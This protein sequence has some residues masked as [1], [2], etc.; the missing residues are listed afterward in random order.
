MDQALAAIH[1]TA[2]RHD[3]L[4]IVCGACVGSVGLF[5]RPPRARAASIKAQLYAQYPDAEID[6][7]PEDSLAAPEGFCCVTASVWLE[8]HLFPI[9]RYAQA[10]D[11]L[12]R[13]LAD[14]VAGILAALT[15]VGDESIRPVIELS[16]QPASR[17]A[18]KRAKR[19]LKRLSRPTFI[20]H[21]AL[22]G[23][24]ARM[25]LSPRSTCRAMAWIL[26]R[27]AQHGPTLQ[28]HDP[29]TVTGSKG[30]DRE[31]DR[32]AAADKLGRHCFACRLRISVAA[33]PNRATQARAKISE[34]FGALGT[35]SQPRLASFRLSKRRRLPPFLLS[36]EEVA[37]LF[38]LPIAAVQHPALAE[39]NVRL[40][41]APVE[42]PN[43]GAGSDT[44]LLG[45]TKFR[46]ER[47]DVY[48]G[49]DALARHA[50]LT[51][52]TGQGKT[53][54][55]VQLILSQIQNNQSLVFI[56]PHGDAYDLV[57]AHIPRHRTNDVVLVDPADQSHAVTLNLLDCPDPR[58]RPQV[59]SAVVAAFQKVFAESW[60]PRLHYV[61]TNSV[62]ALLETPDC[63]LVSLVRLLS[64]GAFR[65]DV[66]HRLRDPGVRAFWLNEF[67]P[68]SPRQ[69]A[70]W[71]ASVQN[72]VGIFV[73]SPVLRNAFG[74]RTSTLN[75][76][77]AL[78]TGRVVLVNLST[79]RLG[80]DV[81]ALYGS[82]FVTAVQLAVFSR[83]DVAP[84]ARR[85]FTL[86]LDEFHFLAT[87]S[88]TT[89]LSEARKFGG[90]L[91][92]ATQFLEQLDPGT[93]AALSGNVGNWVVFQCGPR[94]AEMLASILGQPVAP[95][96]LLRLPQYH[97]IVRLLVDGYPTRPF[98]MTTL[99]LVANHSAAQNAD[100][101]RRT[102]RHRYAIQVS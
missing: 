84:V 38:H 88:L 17:H 37:S 66:V 90:R 4:T 75:L 95:E 78:D 87:T 31:D 43:R 42:L 54:V 62:L 40:F 89:F 69:K 45:R 80:A 74:H 70:D 92:C 83:A 47:R 96:D 9:R 101:L 68:L 6:E 64:D 97:A 102:S 77:Q 29:T 34:V 30:H 82:L 8:P 25:A 26:G 28:N 35:F 61:L 60:G 5:L 52:K 36:T 24:Y 32:Q 2:G 11:E 15:V 79:G 7:L 94:D 10:T 55:L 72:K 33:P 98:T 57:A 65:R 100:T 20:K 71:I 51:G 3:H 1:Q 48:L 99:P 81:A 49:S 39:P 53:T 86:F 56:D 73:T 67:E 23:W 18:M 59:A 19:V 93:L 21:T 14:P 85:P 41:P 58:L 22:A 46:G 44:V 12:N 27:F 50:V 16:L 76:R 63:T 13:V 91:V